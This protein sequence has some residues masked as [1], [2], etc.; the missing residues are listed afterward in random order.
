MDPLQQRHH[1]LAQA[2]SSGVAGRRRAVREPREAE[3][4]TQQSCR[5]HV[6]RLRVLSRR[7]GGGCG[8]KQ[9]VVKGKKKKKRV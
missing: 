7:R 8:F 4:E 3:E 6:G 1:L 2:Q 5:L 9:P